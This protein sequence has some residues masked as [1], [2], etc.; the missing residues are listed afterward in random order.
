MLS[1][2]VIIPALNEETKILEAIDSALVAGADEVIVVDGG[3]TDGTVAAANRL[4]TTIVSARTGRAAQQNDGAARASS[5]VL[6][7]LHADC[8]LSEG[9][10]TELRQRCQ[11]AK[12]FSAG[13]FR[14]RID[15]PGFGYRIAEAG[16]CWRV[17]L[18]G[19][20]YG[21]QA[22]FMRTDL[23]RE[24]GGFPDV[25]F[26]EDL[27][28]M[29]TVK[30]HGSLLMLNSR[31]TVSARRWQRRGLL[32]QTLRNWAIVLAAQ[33]GASPNWLAKFYPNDR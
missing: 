2:A 32:G 31:V 20:A 16:N 15:E 33:L 1:V 3:S 29:K 19:W 21:D 18:L 26:L 13:C 8:Q 7:F 12:T 17:R 25:P 27:L 6:V 30:R 5:D 23:F 28:L 11:Q 22:I 10:L 4:T 9:A 14:Q 24:L